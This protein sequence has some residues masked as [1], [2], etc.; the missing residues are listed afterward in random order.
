MA[1]GQGPGAHSPAP[2]AR[3]PWKGVPG[4]TQ[5][6]SPVIPA[7]PI[8]IAI[9][10]RPRAPGRSRFG[11]RDLQIPRFYATGTL[12]GRRA[13]G[14][15]PR[16]RKD[17]VKTLRLSATLVALTLTASSTCAAV[18]D[19]SN[20]LGPSGGY[21]SQAYYQ[22][23]LGGQPMTAAQQAYADQEDQLRQ[24]GYLSEL[25]GDIALGQIFYH[26][27][28]GITSPPPPSALDLTSGEVTCPSFHHAKRPRHW[29]FGRELYGRRLD[30]DDLR[31]HRRR[32]GHCRTG[33]VDLGDDADRFRGPWPCCLSADTETRRG[34][35]GLASSLPRGPGDQR[36]TGIGLRMITKPDR[37]SCATSRSATTFAVTSAA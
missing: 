1:A 13:K 4:P 17:F 23:M 33:D 25:G 24:L 22:G 16:D 37:S 32:P 9:F 29:R 7:P 3:K 21:T 31:Q 11:G 34:P 35:D 28:Y 36:P 2:P 10:R 12:Y 18:I 15:A 19:L 8:D 6:R 26:I 27:A 30:A 20:V 5:N 14:P